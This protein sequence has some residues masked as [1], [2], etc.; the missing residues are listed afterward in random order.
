MN[1]FVIILLL[2]ISYLLGSVPSGYL[3]G[4]HIKKVDIT[5]SGSKNT[6]AT[7]TT[8][9]LGPKLG[10]IALLFDLIKGI[11]IMSI[12]I[13][14]KLEQLYLVNGV[15]ILSL[16]GIIAV[17]G[18]VFSIFLNFKGGKAV[19][20]SA[21]V[22]LFLAPIVGL[23]TITLFIVIILVTKYVSLGSIIA[24][25]TGSL[26][27]LILSLTKTSNFLTLATPN[28]KTIPL[29]YSSSFIV[30]ALLIAI[31]HHQNIV[32]LINKEENKI[33]FKKSWKIA[34]LPNW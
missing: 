20:T 14:F 26:L 22:L 7:N 4:K 34:S 18:H 2:I 29:F 8:R 12:L 21:G 25:A 5:K 23:I 3:L 9:I 15:N 13:I 11:I 30:L 19:A 17:F 32:R 6:G 1:Y 33:K 24:S 28:L 16:Y 10:V 27:S 31:R